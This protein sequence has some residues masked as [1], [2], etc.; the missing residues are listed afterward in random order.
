MAYVPIPSQP[1]EPASPRA[2]ELGQKIRETIE[3][4]ERHYPGTDAA[5]VRRALEIAAGETNRTR[6]TVSVM[7]GLVLAVVLGMLVALM[8]AG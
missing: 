8:A 4:F 1:Q 5:D 6:M 2:R 3:E 7:V